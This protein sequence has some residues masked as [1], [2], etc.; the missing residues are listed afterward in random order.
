[1]AKQTSTAYN[2]CAMK[3][4]GVKKLDPGLIKRL[5][6]MRNGGIKCKVAGHVLGEVVELRKEVKALKAAKKR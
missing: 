2:K 1:M 3:A 4:A 5:Q 6:D